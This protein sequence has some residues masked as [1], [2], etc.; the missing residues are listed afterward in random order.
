MMETVQAR[1]PGARVEGVMV[2]EMIPA[3]QEVIVGWKRDPQFGPLLLVGSGG[4]EVEL[5]RDVAVEIA[6]LTHGEAERMLSATVAGRRLSGWRGAPPA[7]R[8]AVIDVLLRLSQMALDRPEVA[9]LEINP[10][11]VFRDGEGVVAV[12]GRAILEPEH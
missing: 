3:G 7:D 1:R 2:Q 5:V 12:D 8:Q 11:R 10:L 6:P 9:E 4:T